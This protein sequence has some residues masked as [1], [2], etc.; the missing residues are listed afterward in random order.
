[1]SLSQSWKMLTAEVFLSPILL[2]KPENKA[3]MKHKFCWWMILGRHF[4]WILQLCHWPVVGCSEETQESLCCYF[5]VWEVVWGY[6][7]FFSWNYR[8]CQVLV[9]E[10]LRWLNRNQ[11][12]NKGSL[13]CT[14]LL[15]WG[16]EVCWDHFSVLSFLLTSSWNY[17]CVFCLLVFKVR[18]VL[19][20]FCLWVVY[21]W[22]CSVFLLT[23]AVSWNLAESHFLLENK[24]CSNEWQVA[25]QWI[26]MKIAALCWDLI[27]ATVL[28]CWI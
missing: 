22:S 10:H 7:Q 17:P 25:Y 13:C 12:S 23:L 6:L 11:N 9:S 14:L 21:F 4:R 27:G 16:S 3:Q 5:C 24:K 1:M 15:R 2:K 8:D 20:S 26:L 19:Q 18:K 28:I